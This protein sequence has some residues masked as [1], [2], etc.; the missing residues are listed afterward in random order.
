MVFKHGLDQYK[1]IF[2]WLHGLQDGFKLTFQFVTL[3]RLAIAGASLVVT[4][5]VRMFLAGTPLSACRKIKSAHYIF[6]LLS[7]N[8]PNSYIRYI[9]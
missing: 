1:K 8:F 7:R 2:S 3:D 5:I 9:K 4:K 6:C